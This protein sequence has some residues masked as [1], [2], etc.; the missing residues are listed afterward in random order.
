ML[1]KG[2]LEL[3]RRLP[4]LVSTRLPNSGYT[5]ILSSAFGS[6][7]DEVLDVAGSRSQTVVNWDTE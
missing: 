6:Y 3:R 4:V 1:L 2:L 7:N 5:L